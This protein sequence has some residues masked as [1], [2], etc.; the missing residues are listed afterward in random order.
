MHLEAFLP[1]YNLL[2]ALSNCL[3]LRAAGCHA[4]LVLHAF[5]ELKRPT[6][7]GFWISVRTH[8]VVNLKIK[9]VWVMLFAS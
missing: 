7:R 6:V 9:D 3:F 8:V 5:W 4:P 1:S 2:D